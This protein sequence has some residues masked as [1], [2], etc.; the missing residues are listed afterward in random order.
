MD[1]NKGINDLKEKWL[2]MMTYI[3]ININNL[4]GF[5]NID[6]WKKNKQ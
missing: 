3:S 4:W 2:K 5:F 6:Y 1:V